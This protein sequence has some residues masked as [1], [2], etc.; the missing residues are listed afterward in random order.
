MNNNR[1]VIGISGG[2]D[3]AVGAYLLKEQGY[4]V[5]GMHMVLHQHHA[6]KQ[7][8]AVCK[9]LGIEFHTLNLVE[10]FKE[11]II[12]YFIDEYK[13]GRTP[14]PCVK[15]N[16]LIKFGKVL[17]FCDKMDAKYVAT[18]HYA[19]KDFVDGKYRLK[20]ANNHMKDQTYMLYHLT[21]D[22]LE[23][24]LF[25]L[26]IFNSKA[27]VREK[28]REVGLSVS[29]QS[30]SQDIC[31]IPTNDH[32]EWF[33][34]NNVQLKKG[35]FKTIDG[36]VLG[37]HSGIEKYTIG[38]RKGLGLSGGPFFVTKIESSGDVIVGSN[39]DTFAKKAYL[40]DLHLIYDDIETALKKQLKA[41]V[42]SGAK[43]ALCRV[44]INSDN[45][46]YVIFNEKERAVTPGQ[47]LVLYEDDYVYGGGVVERIEN[48]I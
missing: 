7:A 31:F 23:R 12:S 6:A 32:I 11:E 41:K 16:R 29:S 35:F 36:R 25:P 2:V 22:K 3:S 26:S 42:R 45:K 48:E 37:E 43:Q 40:K 4:E 13:S 5:I 15:C 46:P 8:E 20:M 33:E 44:Y 21:Q 34:D 28:A 10:D 1:V 39:Q 19:A 14:N 17:E 9:E 47:S 24:I 27:D 18:G 38:Q 30:D